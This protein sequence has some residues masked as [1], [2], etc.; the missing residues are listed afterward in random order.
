[1]QAIVMRAPG[2]PAVLQPAEVAAP[3]RQQPDELLI[4]LQ[5]AGVNPIDTKLRGRGTFYPDEMPAILGCD[6]AGIVEAVGPEVEQFQPGDAVYFCYGGLGKS[7]TGNY[8]EVAVVPERFVAPKPSK[9]SFA[10][11]AALPLV[12]ITAWEALYDR[13]RL[14]AEQ[15][16]LIQ[17]GAGGVGHIAIQ[18]A[19]IK[20]ARVCTTVS[21]PDKARLAR[22]LGADETILYPQTEVTAAVLGWTAGK[23]VELAFDTV[24]GPVLAD[25]FAATQVYGDVVTLLAPNITASD[26][27]LARSRNQR[28][29]YELM[30]TPQLQNMT[31]AQRYHGEILRQ[32]AAWV[33]AGR[34]AVHLS[35][36]YPLASAA[37]AHQALESSPTMGKLALAIA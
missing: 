18:L 25:C 20:G 1:M 32:C 12:A 37:A 15:T 3:E 29:S 14:A 11:A 10:E 19:K 23:G 4:R 30:L 35:E 16:V 33:D 26:W 36:T 9:L 6:G 17:A 24:G 7:G 5:A 2:A 31:M 27:K 21:T 28:L 8:A 13:G 22:Q 34:L